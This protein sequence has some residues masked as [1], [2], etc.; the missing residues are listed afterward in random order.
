MNLSA[1]LAGPLQVTPNGQ[2]GAAR[3][4]RGGTHGAID[5]VAADGQAVFAVADGVVARVGFDPP[6]PLGRGGGRYVVERFS[7]GDVMYEAGYFHLASVEV[8][9]GAAL[10]S[11]D[12]VG[13]AGSSGAVSSGAHLHFQ[14]RRLRP[15]ELGVMARE[16]VDP[17]SLFGLAAASGGV[18]PV[19]AVGLAVL[20]L[21]LYA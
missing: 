5:L 15:G 9:A 4:S 20:L 16:V 7:D 19:V 1:P 14:L 18:L 6:V 2:F 11:G 12:R 17:S 10:S 3:P 8:E 13:S 21:V